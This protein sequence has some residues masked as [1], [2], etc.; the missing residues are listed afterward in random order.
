MGNGLCTISC[1]TICLK[2]GSAAC[3]FPNI[4][5]YDRSLEG[6]ALS[7][8]RLGISK[9]VFEAVKSLFAAIKGCSL[10]TLGKYETE[11]S[12]FLDL[13]LDK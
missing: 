5:L 8:D 13:I 11:S 4:C 6:T 3:R 9:F 7:G 2:F 1:T 12:A 10:W